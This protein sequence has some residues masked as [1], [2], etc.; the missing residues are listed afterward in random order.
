ML[1]GISR[2]K[3]GHLRIWDA[4]CG[5]GLM[6]AEAAWYGE[7]VA[8]DSGERQFRRRRAVEKVAP[9]WLV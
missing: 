3:G 2:E 5:T 8:T 1:E 4:G 7:V 6:A 9:V